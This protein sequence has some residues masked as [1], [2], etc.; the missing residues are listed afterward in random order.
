MRLFSA[1]STLC[2]SRAPGFQRLGCA[3]SRGSHG[4]HGERSD[5]KIDEFD[6]RFPPV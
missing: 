6:H 4:D 3:F 5:E 1:S 2:S